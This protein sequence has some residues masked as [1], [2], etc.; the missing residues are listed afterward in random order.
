MTE[1]SIQSL[2]VGK[3]DMVFPKEYENLLKRGFSEDD[4]DGI[5]LDGI[6]FSRL[7]EEAYDLF[8]LK[9]ASL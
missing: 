8:F 6:K 2:S 5:A 7:I 3:G 1:H 4:G 9:M